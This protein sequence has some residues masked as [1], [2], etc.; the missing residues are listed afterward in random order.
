MAGKKRPQGNIETI[1]Q[2]LTYGKSVE[3]RQQLAKNLT[4]IHQRIEDAAKRAGRS[5]TEIQLIGVTKYVDAETTWDLIDA[6]SKVLG[7][8]RPQVFRDKQE[9]LSDLDVQWHLIGHLQRNKIKHVL[10]HVSLIHSVDSLRLIEALEEFASKTETPVNI[11][12]EVNIS[13][14]DAKHGFSETDIVPALDWVAK[15][16]W[17]SA[18]GMMGMSRW[19]GTADEAKRE[20]ESL[21]RLQELLAPKFNGSRVQLEQLSMGMTGDFET[22]IAAGS[23]MVRIGSALF[24]GVNDGT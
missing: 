16:K 2:L 20:F 12:L 19:G 23:T 1:F 8:N 11:L 7:E 18:Q 5:P 4:E 15:S 6:G 9:K 21:R 13:G 3:R 14:E 24:E 22:A 17:L 10:P